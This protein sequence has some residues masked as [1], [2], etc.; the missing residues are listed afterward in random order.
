MRALHFLPS[1]K[2]EGAEGWVRAS[3]RFND[4]STAEEPTPGPSLS[5][6]GG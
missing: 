3:A 1:S 5:G 4:P 6:R 2:R